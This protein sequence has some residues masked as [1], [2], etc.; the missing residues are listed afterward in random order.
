MEDTDR[1]DLQAP[2]S[3]KGSCVGR[4][5]KKEKKG[6]GRIRQA[7]DKIAGDIREA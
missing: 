3:D 4:R 6:K 7:V 5:R 2:H 1:K